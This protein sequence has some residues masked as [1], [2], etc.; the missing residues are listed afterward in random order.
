LSRPALLAL[1]YDGLSQPERARA[2]YEATVAVGMRHVERHSDD[3][4]L[5]TLEQALDRAVTNLAWII[6]EPDW[7]QLR[8]LPRFQALLNRLR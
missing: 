5:D 7:S 6:N 3:Q 4:A 2:S 1:T 8:S